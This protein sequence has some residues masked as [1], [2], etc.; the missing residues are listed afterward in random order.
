MRSK[1]SQFI[2]LVTATRVVVVNRCRGRVGLG[3]RVVHHLLRHILEEVGGAVAPVEAAAEVD[4]RD[5]HA[6]RDDGR[7]AKNEDQG[8]FG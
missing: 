7:Q 1:V 8:N 2:Y 5:D 3:G 6:H 4:G